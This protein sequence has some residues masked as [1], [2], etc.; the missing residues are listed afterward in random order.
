MIHL[1]AS[2]VGS[3]L[4]VFV[5]LV[6]VSVVVLIGY[7]IAGAVGLVKKKEKPAPPPPKGRALFLGLVTLLLG[8]LLVVNLSNRE[9]GRR[10]ELATVLIVFGVPVVLCFCLVFV[11]LFRKKK[12]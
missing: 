5:W 2:G 3:E 1:I 8:A 9:L 10:Y 7:V 12:R 6:L 11:S 4:T